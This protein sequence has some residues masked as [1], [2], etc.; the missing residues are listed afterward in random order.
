VKVLVK[1]LVKALVHHTRKIWK[2]AMI[3]DPVF[4]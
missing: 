3:K 2:I 4:D 1:A